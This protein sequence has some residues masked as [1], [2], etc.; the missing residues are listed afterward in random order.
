MTECACGCGGQLEPTDK[1]GR[2][3]R[4][5]SGHN[6]RVDIHPKRKNGQ[7]LKRGHVYVFHAGPHPRRGKNDGYVAR[8]TLVAEA[9]LGRYLER[10]EVVH[11]INRDKA[12]DR[13]ENLRV[14]T[15]AEHIALHNNE[16]APKGVAAQRGENVWS[17]KLTVPDVLHMRETRQRDPEMSFREIGAMYGVSKATASAAVAGRSWKRLEAKARLT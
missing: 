6:G 7:V 11:H 3:R 13:I 8:A 16:D 5:I 12:D 10:H 17:A 2:V 4:F 9:A 14:M 15:N 1:R